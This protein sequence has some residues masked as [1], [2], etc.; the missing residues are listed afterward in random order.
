MKQQELLSRTAGR[1][2]RIFKLEGRRDPLGDWTSSIKLHPN[3][4]LPRSFTTFQ[5]EDGKVYAVLTRHETINGTEYDCASFA[6]AQEIEHNDDYS[7]VVLTG[8]YGR[9]TYQEIKS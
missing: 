6:P 9:L 4:L 7:E 8:P 5:K 3:H 2:Y 1:R